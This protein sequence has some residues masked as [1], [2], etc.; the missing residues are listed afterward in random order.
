MSVKIPFSESKYQEWVDKCKVSGEKG[1]CGWTDE[2]CG[3][4]DM[5]LFCDSCRRTAITEAPAGSPA[6]VWAS[7]QQ[8]M[9]EMCSKKK[10]ANSSECVEWRKSNPGRGVPSGYVKDMSDHGKVFCASPKAG[11]AKERGLR[12]FC[13]DPREPFRWNRQDLMHARERTSAVDYGGRHTKDWPDVCYGYVNE[14]IKHNK[15]WERS[16]NLDDC[17][18]KEMMKDKHARLLDRCAGL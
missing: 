2:L 5:P 10:D 9:E 15:C 12:E 4:R 13:G 8:N 7:Q 16:R 1:M 17:L 3:G 18:E 11:T 6:G 14:C